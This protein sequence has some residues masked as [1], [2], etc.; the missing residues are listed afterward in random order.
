MKSGAIGAG[1][2]AKWQWTHPFA[3]V[4]YGAYNKFKMATNFFSQSLSFWSECVAY[5]FPEGNV[6]SILLL[7]FWNYITSTVFS[8]EI[9]VKTIDLAVD[10]CWNLLKV[11]CTKIVFESSRLELLSNF[12]LSNCVMS[13]L[14]LH[15]PSATWHCESKI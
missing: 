14:Y 6:N 3:S 5:I 7:L 2:H 15:S 12:L 11:I 13:Q 10:I 9:F 1:P 8:Q 4:S